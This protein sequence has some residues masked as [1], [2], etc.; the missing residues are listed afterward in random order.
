MKKKI[1]LAMAFCMLLLVG[2]TSAFAIQFGTDSY[3][4]PNWG[5]TKVGTVYVECDGGFERKS[6][7][8]VSYSNTSLSKRVALAEG[9]K[10]ISEW[11]DATPKKWLYPGNKSAAYE[12]YKYNSKAKSHNFEPTNN[13]KITY[14]FSPDYLPFWQ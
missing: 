7:F 14:E 1:M 10:E 9:T 6:S 5:Q 13:T 3:T 8:N 12:G 4:V 11:I 2:T